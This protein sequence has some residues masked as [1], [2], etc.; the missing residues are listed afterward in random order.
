ML[1]ILLGKH[2]NE[3]ISQMGDGHI[4][5]ER[6]PGQGFWK[7]VFEDGSYEYRNAYT[8]SKIPTSVMEMTF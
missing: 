4:V 2:M 5:K 6:I 8:G 3:Q 1:F 7:I